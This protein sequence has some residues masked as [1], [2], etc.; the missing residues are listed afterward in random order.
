MVEELQDRREGDRGLKQEV[1]I[2][3]CVLEVGRI[4]ETNQD[5][6]SKKGQT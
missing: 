3:L 5:T 1:H 6:V 4:K 2:L